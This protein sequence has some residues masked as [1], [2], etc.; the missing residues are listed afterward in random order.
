[1]LLLGPSLGLGFLSFPPPLLLPLSLGRTD[2]IVGLVSVSPSNLS[3][4]KGR[5]LGLTVALVQ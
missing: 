4:Q 5:D 3:C 1:M 2:E